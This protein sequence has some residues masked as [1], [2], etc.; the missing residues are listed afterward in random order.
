MR[1]LIIEDDDRVSEALSVFLRKRGY[2]GDGVANKLKDVKAV[3]LMSLNDAWEAHKVRNQIA[4]EGSAFTLSAEL[5][6]RT[7]ARYEKVFREW[8]A[9]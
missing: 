8:G 3:D 7:M 1:I 2:V 9:I 4:H 5:A 6:Q